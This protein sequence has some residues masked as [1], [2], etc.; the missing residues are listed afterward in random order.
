MSLDT[1]AAIVGAVSNRVAGASDFVTL[2]PRSMN[3]EKEWDVSYIARV[4]SLGSRLGRL[5][6]SRFHISRSGEWAKYKVHK[7]WCGVRV[8]SGCSMC[9]GSELPVPAVW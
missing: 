9:V 6:C 8:M 1:V 2:S 3:N 5:F 7:L 4:E